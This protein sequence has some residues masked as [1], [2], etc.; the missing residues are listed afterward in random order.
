MMFSHC[1]RSY[2]SG[3]TWEEGKALLREKIHLTDLQDDFLDQFYTLEQG[4]MHVIDYTRKYKELFIK[5]RVVKSE[6]MTIARFKS[7]LRFGIK[8]ESLMLI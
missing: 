2:T 5:S 8:K 1:G 6:R 3:L 4:N 7:G